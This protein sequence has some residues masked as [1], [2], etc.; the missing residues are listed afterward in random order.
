M[1]RFLSRNGESLPPMV[2][3]VEQRRLP[4]LAGRVYVF[5]AAAWRERIPEPYKSMILKG[6]KMK[7]SARNQLAGKV[8]NVTKGAVNAEVIVAL[9]G[10][11]TMVAIITNASAESLGL[12]KDK[13]ALAIVKASE[14]II[15]KGL[16]GATLSARNVLAGKVVTVQDGAVNSEVVVRLPGGAQIA[17]SITKESVRKLG[18]KSGDPVSAIVKASN[19]MIGV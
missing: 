15:G 18:L 16:N 2:D 1:A 3:L 4:A 13:D 19:V 14:V 11:E 12:A 10:G 9:E 8:Q 5:L 7:I 6:Q 17:A